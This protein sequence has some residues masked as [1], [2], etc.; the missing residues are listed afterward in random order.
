LRVWIGFEAKRE[1]VCLTIHPMEGIRS[2]LV[3]ASFI[4]VVVGLI[5]L[6][7]DF[8]LP[9]QAGASSPQMLR[10]LTH[11]HCLP[12]LVSAFRSIWPAIIIFGLS[13]SPPCLS[14]LT[15][16]FFDILFKL[17]RRDISRFNGLHGMLIILNLLLLLP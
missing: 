14:F 5:S 17:I 6:K 7:I 11:P 15:I 2:I 13:F 3:A 9:L 4:R 1:V 8:A 12:I 10:T 16:L